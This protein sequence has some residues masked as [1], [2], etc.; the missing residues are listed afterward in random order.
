MLPL[1][2]SHPQ[3]VVSSFAQLTKADEDE[4]EIEGNGYIFNSCAVLVIIF[5]RYEHYLTVTFFPPF[6]ATLVI[7]HAANKNLTIYINKIQL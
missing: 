4:K 3:T 6:G 7:C 5:T 1:L 2:P